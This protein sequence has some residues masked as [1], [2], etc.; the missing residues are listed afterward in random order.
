MSDPRFQTLH[1]AAWRRIIVV[2]SALKLAA[3]TGLLAAIGALIALALAP[4]L[5]II[6]WPGP[7]I[8]LSSGLGV[9][10]LADK[11]IEP[12]QESAKRWFLTN[13]DAAELDRSAAESFWDMYDWDERREA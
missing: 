6:G 9:A 10:F 13:T 12:V 11:A 7:A 4:L 8:V 1:D 5:P 3:L 2:D